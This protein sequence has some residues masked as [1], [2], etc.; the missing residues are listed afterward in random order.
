MANDQNLI[1]LSQRTKEEQREIQSK[2]GKASGEVRRQRQQ[3]RE[4]IQ[5]ILD[6]TY[7]VTD[8][9]SGKAM[10]LTGEQIITRKIIEVI[11]DTN[12]KHWFETLQLLIEMTDSNIPASELALRERQ[13]EK[14]LENINSAPD[15]DFSSVLYNL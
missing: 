9:S 3:L 12:N 13:N 15:I 5:G 11:N 8:S 7:K 4:A 10:Q 14:T 1:P 6:S 2:G